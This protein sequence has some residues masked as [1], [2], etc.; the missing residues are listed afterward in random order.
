MNLCL[1][2]SLFRLYY[3]FLSPIVSLTLF[4]SL[5]FQISVFL[6]P[7]S[8][9]CLSLFIFS[10]SRSLYETISLSGLLSFCIS[11]LYCLSVSQC[12][13]KSIFYIFICLSLAHCLWLLSFNTHL[14]HSVAHFLPGSLSLSLSF[15]LSVSL[16][17]S[18]SLSLSLSQ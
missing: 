17:I 18:L 10:L 11:Q 16:C 6:S 8:L 14:Y 9:L 7:L 4:F 15:Y 5:S 13:S 12:L 3:V 2:V 1:S